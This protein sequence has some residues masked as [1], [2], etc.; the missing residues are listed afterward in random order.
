MIIHE[1]LE[2][3]THTANFDTT[4]VVVPGLQFECYVF[5]FCFAS[6]FVRRFT[7]TGQSLCTLCSFVQLVLI[8]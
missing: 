4:R 3:L 5:K 6:I 8:C 1:G 2:Y 7:C